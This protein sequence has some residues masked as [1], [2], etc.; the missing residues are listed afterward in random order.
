[1]PLVTISLSP[2]LAAKVKAAVANGRYASDSE[3]VRNAL[4]QWSEHQHIDL[5][6]L[7]RTAVKPKIDEHDVA[8]LYSTFM[9]KKL[10]G[11]RS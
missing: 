6:K 5:S 3:V 10:D 2:E 9:S 8:R 11:D 7:P 4:E 1:M